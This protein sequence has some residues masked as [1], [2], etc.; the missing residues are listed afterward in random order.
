ML[1]VSVC[2]FV[3]IQNGARCRDGFSLLLDTSTECLRWNP[4]FC[5]VFC[6]DSDGDLHFESGES[7]LEYGSKFV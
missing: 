1:A 3:E 7:N 5:L 6:F 2:L 4:H